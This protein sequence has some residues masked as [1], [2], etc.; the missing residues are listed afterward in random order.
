MCKIES[1]CILNMT[2]VP[3]VEGTDAN[4]HLYPIHTRC[5]AIAGSTARCG[6]KFWYI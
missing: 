4:S 5:H 1:E 6:C 3:L 2:Y